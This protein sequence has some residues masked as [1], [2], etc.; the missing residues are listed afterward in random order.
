MKL[1][2]TIL[3]MIENNLIGSKTFV[4]KQ[5]EQVTRKIKAQNNYQVSI[6]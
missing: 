5:Y 1:F 2:S 3:V 4:H 6:N